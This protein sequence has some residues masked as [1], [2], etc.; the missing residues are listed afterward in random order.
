MGYS[1]NLARGF[2]GPV[3]RRVWLRSCS[4]RVLPPAQAQQSH[5]RLR[6]GIR[7]EQWTVETTRAS[8]SAQQILFHRISRARS[9]ELRP[10]VCAVWPGEWT[11]RDR[12]RAVS[13]G[14]IR[15][16]TRRTATIAAC[17]TGRSG[18]LMPVP[19]ETGASDGDLEEKYVT[20]RYRVWLTRPS[21]KMSTPISASCRLIRRLWNALWNNCVGFRPQHRRIMGLKVP[22]ARLAGAGGF[23]HGDC[24]R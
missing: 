3:R 1:R 7:E 6:P 9:R 19:S 22:T 13:L 24:A 15:P 20:A 12:A 21:T 17:S 23:R 16:A 5:S 14:C 18:M 4:A 8:P 2:G 11:R 10:Y